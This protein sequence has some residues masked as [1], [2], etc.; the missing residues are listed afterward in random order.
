MKAGKRGGSQRFPG[1]FG[2]TFLGILCL[3]LG[4]LESRHCPDGLGHFYPRVAI[5]VQRGDG[6]VQKLFG[7]AQIG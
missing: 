5:S 6:R 4:D 7:D 2:A 3:I 1:W